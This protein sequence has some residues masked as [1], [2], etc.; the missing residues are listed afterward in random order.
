M[1]TQ[2]STFCS[3]RTRRQQSLRHGPD[4][5]LQEPGFLQ[6]EIQTPRSHAAH[7][8]R[9]FRAFRGVSRADSGKPNTIYVIVNACSACLRYNNRIHI[10][11]CWLVL[12]GWKAWISFAGLLSGDARSV[13]SEVVHLSDKQRNWSA[14]ETFSTPGTGTILLEPGEV[15]WNGNGFRTRDDFYSLN[16]CFI[17]YSATISCL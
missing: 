9:F 12:A 10:E 6:L 16:R 14:K 2:S 1:P 5:E 8:S 17:G 13:S 15:K 11:G 3:V 7:R 4:Y